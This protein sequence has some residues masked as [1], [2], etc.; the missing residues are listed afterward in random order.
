MESDKNNYTQL[1]NHYY[2][3]PTDG[4]NDDNGLSN[5]YE[6]LKRIAVGIIPTSRWRKIS[7]TL[8]CFVQK[9]EIRF[10]ASTV[11]CKIGLNIISCGSP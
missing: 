5:L 2:W 8:S 1:W 6:T 3:V 9:L 7:G 4:E 11:I 10:N